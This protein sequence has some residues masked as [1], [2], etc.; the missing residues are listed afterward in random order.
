M[1]HLTSLVLFFT[2]V[3]MQSRA[4]TNTGNPFDYMSS[5]TPNLQRNYAETFKPEDY[6]CKETLELESYQRNLR[7]Y[8][9]QLLQQDPF[10][11]ALFDKLEKRLD[12]IVSILE[13]RYL[14]S[15]VSVNKRQAEEKLKALDQRLEK[16][17]AA[18][19]D[20]EK[21]EE[22]PAKRQRKDPGYVEEVR[23]AKDALS[24]LKRAYSPPASQMQEE[25]EN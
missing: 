16:V 3:T 5:K 24:K 17:N 4:L 11:A 1:S 7:N 8:L 19:T 14:A 15:G 22:P 10:P 12:G 20:L 6:E 2:S 13:K 21:L 25:E 23:K 18:A 9:L